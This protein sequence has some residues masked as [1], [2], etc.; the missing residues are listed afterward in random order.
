MFLGQDDSNCLKKQCFDTKDTVLKTRILVDVIQ[1]GDNKI[2]L[3]SAWNLQ[4]GDRKIH[5]CELKLAAE[6]IHLAHLCL[7]YWGQVDYIGNSPRTNTEFW[8]FIQLIPFND[9]KP[10]WSRGSIL[11]S[12]SVYTNEF[13]AS[14]KLSWLI[15]LNAKCLGIPTNLRG[16]G[17]EFR[18]KHSA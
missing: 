14:A 6:G 17:G 5:E 10:F 13:E 18:T 11:D 7:W 15:K 2:L 8:S 9:L 12:L 1:Q 3:L 4:F 16:E